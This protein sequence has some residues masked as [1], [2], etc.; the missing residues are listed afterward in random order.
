M[1]YNKDGIFFLGFILFI[2]KYCLNCLMYDFYGLIVLLNG[3]IFLIK[4]NVVIIIDLKYN[5]M[6]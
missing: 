5:G 1:R 2:V 4:L 6:G 3:L